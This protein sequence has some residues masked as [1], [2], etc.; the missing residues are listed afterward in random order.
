ML[1]NDLYQI[2][3]V[4][5][6]NYVVTAFIEKSTRSVP[7]RVTSEAYKLEV[8]RLLELTPSTLLLTPNMKYTLGVFGGP[9]RGSYGMQIEG[10]HV[11]QKFE[12]DNE[13]IASI[14]KFR[15]ITALK[16]GDAELRYTIVQTKFTKDGKEQKSIVSSR[17]VPVRV[18]L[19]T[20]IE[21]PHN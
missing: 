21:I 16:V 17:M 4:E 14:D 20:E 19:V 2:K 6:G 18:R 3:G 10:S 9:S 11:E 1:R 8:F 15:E 12:I 5:P 13:E 7:S